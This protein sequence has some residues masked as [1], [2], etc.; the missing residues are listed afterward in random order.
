MSGRNDFSRREFIETGAAVATALI[1]SVSG[2]STPVWA[3]QDSTLTHA[4]GQAA[5]PPRVLVLIEL[6]GGNDG[7]N[8]VIPYGSREYYRARPNIAIDPQQVLKIKQSD[9]LG[10]HPELG[11][12][13]ELLDHDM[14]AVIHGVGYPRPDRSHEG[15]RRVWHTGDTSNRDEPAVGWVAAAL[16]SSD[17][18]LSDRERALRCIA[19]GREVP[20]VFQGRD[21]QPWVMSRPGQGQW[22]GSELNEAIKKAYNQ[23]QVAANPQQPEPSAATAS[24]LDYVWRL[25]THTQNVSRYIN[26]VDLQEVLTGFP[27]GRLADQLRLVARLIA[28]RCPAEVYYVTIDGFDTHA[29][30]VD[31]HGQ[32]LWH[33]AQGIHGFYSELIAAKQQDRVLTVAFSEFGRR[34]E[35]NFSD[36]T[37]HGTAGP[38]FV[39]G[40]AVEPGFI[41]AYPSLSNLDAGDLKMTMDFRSIYAAVLDD[42]MGIDS[43]QVLGQSFKAVPLIRQSPSDTAP[44]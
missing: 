42:W 15:S 16:R 25:A 2:P 27:G 36:G 7:L 33:F 1:G 37:D 41:G 32:S 26:Q 30:Q 28:A 31:L 13:K 14:A 4:D 24:Q 44:G 19:I 38:V 39:F 22:A 9:G 11:A 35:Q 40:T 18:Q 23:I 6:G 29:R 20:I 21:P 43:R 17:A 10:L 12:I 8:T 3:A 34:V 5:T